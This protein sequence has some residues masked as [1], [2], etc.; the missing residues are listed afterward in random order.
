MEYQGLPEHR[1]AHEVISKL[2]R[3][4]KKELE[5]LQIQAALDLMKFYRAWLRKHVQNE[6]SKYAESI[7][8]AAQ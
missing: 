2:L 7:R 8:N 3:E 5:Q 1:A 4:M 6:D